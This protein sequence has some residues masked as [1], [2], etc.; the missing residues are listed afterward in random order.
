MAHSLLGDPLQVLQESRGTVSLAKWG[1]GQVGG[2]GVEEPRVTDC[3][4][5]PAAGTVSVGTSS[6]LSLSQHPSPT[7]VFRHHYI[8]YFRGKACSAQRGVLVPCLRMASRALC[9][10][11][12]FFLC[13][14]CLA[15]F[16][17]CVHVPGRRAGLVCHRKCSWREHVNEHLAPHLG[18]HWSHWTRFPINPLWWGASDSVSLQ[19]Q[20][21]RCE[22]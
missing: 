2:S 21:L 18:P 7:S 9:L 1:L 12:V 22:R 11:P 5:L 3:S 20:E 14:V 13:C 10:M 6:C 15:L 4:L 8:P 17:Q 16:R 19:E